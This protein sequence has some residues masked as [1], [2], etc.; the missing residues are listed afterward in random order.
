MVYIQSDLR[1]LQNKSLIMIL[2]SFLYEFLL[3]MILLVFDIALIFILISVLI[4]ID[5]LTS[6]KSS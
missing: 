6:N 4:Y 2:R 5:F 1:F 3:A